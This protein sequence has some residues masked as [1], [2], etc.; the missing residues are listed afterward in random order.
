[1]TARLA[2]QRVSVRNVARHGQSTLDRLGMP[3]RVELTRCAIRR[4][5]G[6]RVVTE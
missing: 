3:D 4:G 6:G 2:E 1:M 5:C